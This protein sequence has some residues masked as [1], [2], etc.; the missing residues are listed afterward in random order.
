MLADI[1]EGTPV[2]S[3]RGDPRQ[4]NGLRLVAVAAALVAII[5][6]G[7]FVLRDRNDESERPATTDVP[8]TTAVAPTPVAT[9]LA[10][11]LETV[12]PTT[13]APTTVAPSSA[14]P[15]SRAPSGPA[16]A[17]ATVLD[18]SFVDAVH[19]WALIPV[20]DTGTGLI[21]TADGGVTWASVTADT[22]N[23]QHVYF[24]DTTRGWMYG[25]EPDGNNGAFRVTRDGGQTWSDVDLGPSGI[26]GPP[27][28][29]AT[30]GTTAAIIAAAPPGTQTVNWV[31]ATA[32]IDSDQFVQNGIGFQQGAGPANAYSLAVEGGDLWAVYND[33][34]VQGVGRMVAGNTAD[35]SVPWSDLGGSATLAVSRGGTLYA[36]VWAGEWTGP[37]VEYQLYVSSDRGNTF[38]RVTLP[39]A[40]QNLSP[41]AITPVTGG[42]VVLM[43]GTPDGASTMYRSTDS[44]SHMDSRALVPRDG[45]GSRALGRWF[46]AGRAAAGDRRQRLDDRH[47]HRRRRNVDHGRLSH[48]H[49]L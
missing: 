7:L 3:H 27:V 49:R 1:T 16:V 47:E 36:G 10:P 39:N 19:G 38:S 32:P 41:V 12:A 34:T 13:V 35:W 14:V 2:V 28:A 20:G 4:G 48:T 6:G 17:L 46:G 40:V 22:T 8:A 11:P 44:G 23:V 45:N 26:Q 42:T 15:T 43:E 33:R 31:V 24:A 9:T 21:Y 18:M 30:D 25:G 29:L 5:V 37:T